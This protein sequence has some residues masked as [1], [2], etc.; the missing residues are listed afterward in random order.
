VLDNK[1]KKIDI[2]KKLNSKTGLSSNFSKKVLND[3]ISIIN[4][5]IKSGKLILKNVGT[6]RVVKKKQRIGRN[7]KTKEEFVI[8]S[9][10][11]ISF[12]SSRIIIDTL[13]K[14]L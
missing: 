14:L 10:K 6:F 13:N 5:N 9:R 11:S 12:I 7:P 8:S 3:L 4:I 1:I 2:I